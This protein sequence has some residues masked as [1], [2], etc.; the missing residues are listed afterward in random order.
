MPRL[1]HLVVLRHASSGLTK[2]RPDTRGRKK[3]EERQNDGYA[4]SSSRFYPEDDIR[5]LTDEIDQE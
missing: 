1:L 4:H 5:D 2:V 3:D